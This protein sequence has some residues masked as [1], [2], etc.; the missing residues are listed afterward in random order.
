[1]IPS[2][3][4][5]EYDAEKIMVTSVSLSPVQVEFVGQHPPVVAS[6]LWCI[7]TSAQ[8]LADGQRN[9]E[10]IWPDQSRDVTGRIHQGR[11]YA[12]DILEKHKVVTLPVM[13]VVY[14][15]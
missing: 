15:K 13:K 10:S 7:Q 14:L 5:H 6:G 2:T 4:N 12:L 8:L 3:W 11:V 9:A 1:M